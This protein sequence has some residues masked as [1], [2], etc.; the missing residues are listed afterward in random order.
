MLVVGC[1]AWHPNGAASYGP[2]NMAGGRALRAVLSG[3][4]ADYRAAMDARDAE[5]TDPALTDVTLT[6]IADAP[7]DFMGDA[8]TSD[9]LEYVLSLY[10]DYYDK[11]S[12]QLAPQ[13]E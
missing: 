3:Q 8:L 5:L 7:A 2:Q 10:A 12:V 6:P 11:A 1:M 13:E 9:N 4:A